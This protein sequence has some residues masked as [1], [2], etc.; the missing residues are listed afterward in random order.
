MYANQ[1][2]IFNKAAELRAVI[3]LSHCE[4]PD[5]ASNYEQMKYQKNSLKYTDWVPRDTAGQWID[6][7]GRQN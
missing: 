5:F 4:I 3:N 6:S 7:G 1:V 2:C